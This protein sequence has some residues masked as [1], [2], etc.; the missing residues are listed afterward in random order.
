M[1]IAQIIDPHILEE[2][3]RGH[4]VFLRPKF[5]EANIR[6]KRG[7]PRI[8]YRWVIIGICVFA[9][10]QNIVWEDLPTKLKYCDFLGEAG[11]L[12]SIPSKSTFHRYWKQ[13]SGANLKSW[14]RMSGK[15]LVTEADQDLAIDS[16]GFE[17]FVGSI[18]RFL[19]WGKR[20]ILKSSPFFVK[21]HLA[22]ALPSKAIVSIE[23]SESTVHDSVAFGAVWKSLYKRIAGLLKRVHLDKAYWSENHINFLEQEGIQAVIPCKSNSI[24]HGTESRM[25]KLVQEHRHMPGLYQRNNCSHLRA[26]VEHVFGE[27]RL[28]H[29][30]LGDIQKTNKVKTLLCSFLW[31]NQ[32]Y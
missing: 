9:R 31:Y 30:I 8:G 19:K 29:V 5:P 7:R 10:M 20:A 16:S 21:V 23:V 2:F 24:D 17:L 3:L 28:F 22:V 15:C 13:V 11:Y 12:R 1:I 18:W 6:S 26:E 14:I 4:Q 25:D 27:V 32:A